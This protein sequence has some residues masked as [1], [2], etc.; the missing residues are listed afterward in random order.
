[1]QAVAVMACKYR[2]ALQAAM[3]M[4]DTQKELDVYW[5]YPDELLASFAVADFYLCF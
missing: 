4:Q 1:M 5:L 3:V 2:E